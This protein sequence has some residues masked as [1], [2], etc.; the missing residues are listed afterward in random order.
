MTA[1]EREG[2]R[3]AIYITYRL[4]RGNP[5]EKANGSRQVCRSNG[6]QE[7]TRRL[8]KIAVMDYDASHG[9]G[10]LAL[11]TRARIII[12]RALATS[13][14]MKSQLRY[15]MKLAPRDIRVTRA[16]LSIRPA[17]VDSIS[18]V[19]LAASSTRNV[20]S[21]RGDVKSRGSRDCPTR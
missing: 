17:A 11:M 10:S 1:D 2:G 6:N 8:G 9:G 18:G 12:R 20:V 21:S 15:A 3:D 14:G 13:R 7:A 4:S 16:S 5:L 19:S